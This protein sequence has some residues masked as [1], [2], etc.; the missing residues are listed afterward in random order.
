MEPFLASE[1]LASGALTFRELKRFHRQV[2]PGVWV[3]RCADLSMIGRS[4]AGWLWSRRNAVLAGLSASA[5]LGAKWI[6]ADTP[7]DMIYTNRRPPTGIVVRTDLVLSGEKV[8]AKGLPVTSPARTAYDLA[9]RLE[10]EGAVPRIDA[11]MNATG[12]EVVDVEAVAR[13]HPRANG[14]CQLRETLPMVDG[15]AE[16]KYES[17]TRLLLVQAGFPR[18]ETQ[19]EVFDD[20]GYFVAR[21]DMGWREFRVGVDF[22][23]AHH[24]TEPRQ[25]S[26]DVDR[27]ARLPELGWKDV[28]L[29]SGIYHNSPQVFLQ[30]VG[31][32]LLAGGCPQT[33]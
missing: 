26:K 3:D 29:T 27:Y 20:N 25:F 28:R 8:V 9:R 21:I 32:A 18:P 16:S 30:R 14:L 24:W 15:G 6:D 12:L 2:F 31:N 22:E 33:W 5:A 10:L 13:R 17:L 4:K 23:G 7:I 19:I 11:L 1:A